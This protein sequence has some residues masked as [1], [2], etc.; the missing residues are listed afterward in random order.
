[1]TYKTVYEWKLEEYE[2]RA[3]GDD[4]DIIDIHHDEK[5]PL[6]FVE[7]AYSDPRHFQIVL[8]RDRGNEIEGLVERDHV[9][10]KFWEGGLIFEGVYQDDGRPVPLKYVQ[11]LRKVNEE[12]IN[13]RSPR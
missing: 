9:Y 5:L 11:E 7:K 10:V 13:Q 6:W 2:D 1:M 3:L 8:V 12:Y 4:A